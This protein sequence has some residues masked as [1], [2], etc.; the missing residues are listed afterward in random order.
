MPYGR[1]GTAPLVFFIS[2]LDYG[3]PVLIGEN[4]TWFA[5]PLEIAYPNPKSIINPFLLFSTLLLFLFVHP[6][7]RPVS[8]LLNNVPCF[9]I[10]KYKP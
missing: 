1:V 9:P 6:N 7:R 8:L 4:T 2:R 3:K 5:L 10:L